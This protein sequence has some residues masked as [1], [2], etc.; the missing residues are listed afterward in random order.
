MTGPRYLIAE[1]LAGERKILSVANLRLFP[2]NG[3]FEQ[4]DYCTFCD[5]AC[6]TP[7][8]SWFLFLKESPRSGRSI[9]CQVGPLDVAEVLIAAGRELPPE[10]VAIVE[11]AGK[12]PKPACP[13]EIGEP[14]VA[15]KVRGREVAT[16]T[17]ARWDV[18]V[19]LVEVWP[20]TLTGDQLIKE[21]KHGSAVNLL[22]QVARLPGWETAFQIPGKPGRGG[23]FGVARE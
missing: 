5:V 8:G 7:D 22:K 4:D 19:T 12:P 10:L 3:W 20:G 2:I 1:G 11:A 13:V 23:G 17:R 15:P 9:Y 21:S 18:V 6:M 16:L 14:D